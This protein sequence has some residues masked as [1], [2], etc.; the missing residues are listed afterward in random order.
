M[1]ATTERNLIACARC[2]RQYDVTGFPPGTRVRCECADLL[3]AEA[4]RPRMPRPLKCGRCGGA[5][6]ADARK[7]DYCEGEITLEERGLSGVC[8]KCFARLLK[9][10]RYCME[11]GVEIAPQA[12]LPVREGA[13]CPRCKGPLRSRTVGSTF[14]VECGN[15]AGL[16]LKQEDLESICERADTQELVARAIAEAVPTR[17]VDAGKGPTY[18]PCPTCGSLMTRRNFGGASGV[19]IDLCRGHGVWLDHRELERIL[20]FVRQGGLLKAR[21]REVERLKREAELAQARTFAGGPCGT[22]GSSESI[23]RPLGLDIGLL[24]ALACL[25]KVISGRISR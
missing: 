6:R 4:R 10:A 9:D 19:L 13:L 8:P 5:L 1:D 7:C 2:G 17:P 12:I 11:C 15:C 3:T 25:A 20:A 24:D 22:G 16:W 21:E 14:F 23:D 18:V